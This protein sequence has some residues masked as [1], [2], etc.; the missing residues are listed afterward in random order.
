MPTDACLRMDRPYVSGGRARTTEVDCHIVLAGHFDPATMGPVVGGEGGDALAALSGPPAVPIQHLAREY[1]AEGLETTI[2][3]GLRGC[4]GVIARSSPLSAI[5]YGKRGRTAWVLDGL[6]RERRLILEYL[7]KIHPS[8]VHAHWTWEAARAVADWTGP[9]VLTVHDAAWEYARLDWDWNWG[10]LAHASTLRWLA[11]T[12]AVLK[13]FRHVIAVSP[14][15]ESYLRLKHRFRGEIRVIPNAIPPLPD[16]V[17]IPETSPK[18]DRVT[19]G[20]YGSPGRLKNVDAALSA[21]LLIYKGLPKSRLLVF[22][23]GWE[24]ASAQYAGMPIEFRGAQPHTDFLGQLAADVDLWVHP[25]R[26]ET[27]SLVICE[28]IQAGC[29]V[30]AGRGSGA[31]PWTLDYGRAGMLVDIEN[32]SEIAQAMLALAHNEDRALQ[33]VSYGRQMILDRFSPDRVV[34]MHL[35]FY[36]DIMREWNS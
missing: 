25:S 14:F 27:H 10:P 20:C 31:V 5:V 11:N 6:R 30:I 1:A 9:K 34:E 3:G 7:R 36:R 21:F 28:A 32:P 29:P 2:L 19:F 22:G 18:T 35:R 16:T 15:V 24:K 4:A 12:S 13:R 33:L 26:I 17:R 8:V 23:G